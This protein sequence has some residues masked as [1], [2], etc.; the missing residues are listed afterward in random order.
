MFSTIK[1]LALSLLLASSLS[2][3]LTAPVPEGE[4]G[5]DFSDY[6]SAS[7]FE[8]GIRPNGQPGFPL[9]GK[10]ITKPQEGHNDTYYSPFK[11]DVSAFKHWCDARKNIEGKVLRI[12]PG[13]YEIP[14]DQTY[15]AGEYP[16]DLGGYIPFWSYPTGLT[17]DLT[18]VTISVPI[19]DDT[20][21]KRNEAVFYINNAPDFTIKGGTIWFDMG[22]TYTYARIDSLSTSA[23]GLQEGEQL[24]TIKI[25][26]GYDLNLWTADAVAEKGPLVLD[27]S[28]LPA[29]IIEVK[30]L[31]LNFGADS[32]Y[33]LDEKLRTAT[34][35][36]RNARP[37]LGLLKQVHWQSTQSIRAEWTGGL[38]VTNLVTNGGFTQIGGTN[39][40][41]AMVVKDSKLVN[42]P[43]RPGF[44]DRYG[45]AAMVTENYYPSFNGEGTPAIEF[46][47]SRY[48]ARG[49]GEDWEDLFSFTPGH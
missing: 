8:G 23:P 19:T 13:T 6:T 17:L 40:G 47:G 24:S 3:A 20:L 10:S 9:G 31:N 26:D 12:A 11:F 4:A 28:G 16:S 33:K 45:G 2:P 7:S 34:L 41:A 18:D 42:P 36:L 49:G 46:P 14:L 1:G 37:N 27:I 5:E 48:Q 25:L 15:P 39:G 44:G 35:K 30:D 22:E 43:L 38:L 21:D 32:D 29:H